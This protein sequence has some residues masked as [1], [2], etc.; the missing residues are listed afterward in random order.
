MK[1]GRELDERVSRAMGWELAKCTPLDKRFAP[2]VSWNPFR[3]TGY[4]W[5]CRRCGGDITKEGP[6]E[7]WCPAIV[8]HWSTDDAA[9]M[10][11]VDEL[12]NWN[13]DDNMLVLKG[14]GDKDPEEAWW[15]A[16]IQGT[17]GHNVGKAK[18]RPHAISLA[19]LK[20]RGID[21]NE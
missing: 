6:T 2:F 17:Q 11:V 13:T 16:D 7:L 10:Q 5:Q 18:T 21:E 20:V 8:K 1:A 14:Q 19:A 3:F 9:A 12:C 15:T 4:T